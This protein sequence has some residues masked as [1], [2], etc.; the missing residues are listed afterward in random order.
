MRASLAALVCWSL[1]AAGCSGGTTPTTDSKKPTAR[2]GF[3]KVEEVTESDVGSG[4]TLTGHV[5]IDEDHS[6]RLS[7]PIDGRVVTLRVRLGDRVQVGQK[8]I[9]LSSPQVGQLQAEA[10][11]AQSDLTLATKALDSGRKLFLGHGLSDRELSQLEADA[12]RARADVARTA[13][14]L[15][16]LH[17]SAGDPGVT[18]ALLSAVSGSVV[19]RNVLVGQE[20]RADQAAPLLTITDLDTVWVLAD[21]YEQDLALVGAGAQ[22]QVRVP[23]W[24]EELFPGTVAHVGDEVDATTRTVKLRCV[25]K[26]P[27]GKLKPEMF[28]RVE[29]AGAT[30]HRGVVVPVRTVLADGEIS[31]VIV[32]TGPDKYTARRIEVGPERDGRVRVLKGLSPHERVVTE[33]ALFLMRELVAP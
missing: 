11:K 1:V 21:V 18:M 6:Q 7:T 27:D 10:Q 29:L 2:V 19:E 28:A 23:A 33:G 3:I 22:V 26:N 13:A 14:Q 24:P 31:Y 8:L 5:S 9:E 16:A 4:L 25:V 30:G 12:R 17:I 32:A 15:S 20:V